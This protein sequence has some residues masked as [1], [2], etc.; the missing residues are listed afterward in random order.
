MQFCSTNALYFYAAS[1]KASFECY[2]ARLNF[3]KY[4]C[5]AE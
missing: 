1:N 4:A 3:Q 2:K 5:G